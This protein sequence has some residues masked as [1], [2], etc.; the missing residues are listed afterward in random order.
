MMTSC[1]LEFNWSTQVCPF[2]SN[3][4]D[5]KVKSRL[6]GYHDGTIA[7]CSMVVLIKVIITKLDKER[8]I[9]AM[10]LKESQD[11]WL[12]LIQIWG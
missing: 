2:K 5:P 10:R 9:L 7:K 3:C 8:Q 6:I 12:T 11:I 1:P 4:R